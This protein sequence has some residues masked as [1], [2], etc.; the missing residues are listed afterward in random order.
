MPDATYIHARWNAVDEL[1]QAFSVLII[2]M[3]P[4]PISRRMTCARIISWPVIRPAVALPTIAASICGLSTPASFIAAFDG[5]AAEVLERL[6]HP[7]AEARHARADD[8][9]SAHL[10]L[11][12]VPVRD[13]GLDVRSR[14]LCASSYGASAPVS[15]HLTARGTRPPAR[16]CTN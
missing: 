5:L 6:V 13:G 9:Y 4:K 3:S 10:K 14:L 2:G 12:L 11:L 1:A 7:L 15:V 8:S 16:R